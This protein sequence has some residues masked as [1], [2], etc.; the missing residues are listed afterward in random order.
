MMGRGYMAGGSPHPSPVTIL[1]M[2]RQEREF[3]ES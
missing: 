2:A 3:L 1:A